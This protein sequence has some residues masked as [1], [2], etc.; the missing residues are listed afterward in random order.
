VNYKQQGSDHK[1]VILEAE[2]Y[3]GEKMPSNLRRAS[4]TVDEK[5]ILFRPRKR[6]ETDEPPSP[7]LKKGP[8]FFGRG[9]T[10]GTNDR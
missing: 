6:I 4:A 9:W 2:V 5:T 8:T 3:I 7:V 1:P 10:R